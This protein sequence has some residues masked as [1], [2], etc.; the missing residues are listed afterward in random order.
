MYVTVYTTAGTASSHTPAVSTA[1]TRW[2]GGAQA[3][4]SGSRAGT[5]SAPDHLLAIA[6]PTEMPHRASQGRT[7]PSLPRSR[8]STANSAAA[9]TNRVTKTSSIASRECTKCRGSIASSPADSVAHAAD[10]N[11]FS[12]SR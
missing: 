6:S 4:N 11:S 2:P 12:A 8:S 3:T 1:R 10:R 9:T 5:I 7:A